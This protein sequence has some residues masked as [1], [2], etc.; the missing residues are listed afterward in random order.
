MKVNRYVFTVLFDPGGR[1]AR[2]QT[3]GIICS[4]RNGKAAG[5]AKVGDNLLRGCFSLVRSD[6]AIIESRYSDGGKYAKNY[7]HQQQFDQ[8]EGPAIGL[9]VWH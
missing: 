3:F 7:D 9:P 4:I 5:E 6:G 2:A 8:A 1:V